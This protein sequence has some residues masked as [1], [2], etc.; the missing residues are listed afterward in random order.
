MSGADLPPVSLLLVGVAAFTLLLWSGAAFPPP[1]GGAA[2]GFSH[3]LTV[4]SIF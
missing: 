3:A 2:E 1:L 4:C